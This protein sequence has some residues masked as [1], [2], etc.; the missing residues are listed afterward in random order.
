MLKHDD[1]AEFCFFFNERRILPSSHCL[2]A[3]HFSW[4][5]L[6]SGPC[7]CIVWT[8]N[9]HSWKDWVTSEYVEPSCR[10]SALAFLRVYRQLYLCYEEMWFR[11]FLITYLPQLLLLPS[12]NY[13]STLDNLLCIYLPQH[14]CEFGECCYSYIKELRHRKAKG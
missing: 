6:P 7:W 8:C 2:C 9:K 3:P 1:S 12:Q 13:V 4:K 10:D 11:L 5:W 14:P